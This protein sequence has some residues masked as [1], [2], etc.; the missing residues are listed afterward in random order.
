MP[1]TKEDAKRAVVEYLERQAARRRSTDLLPFTRDEI[2]DALGFTNGELA[3]NVF[4][5]LDADKAIETRLVRAEIYLPKS[6]HGQKFAKRLAQTG[7]LS[8]SQLGAAALC[9]LALMFIAPGFLATPT[10]ADLLSTSDFYA[11]GVEDGFF[12]AFLVGLPSAWILNN[13][14]NHYARWR[15]VAEGNHAA[16]MR[17]TRYA[18]WS[19]VLSA[20]AYWGYARMTNGAVDGAILIGAIGIG[21]ALGLGYASI[22]QSPNGPSS[23]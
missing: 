6:E 19:M 4:K 13:A 9:I 21:L 3:D 2:E 23:H 17:L 5:E 12:W 14:W 11:R 20:A 1:L 15:L 22:S 16:H 10:E 7:L 8:S 18:I